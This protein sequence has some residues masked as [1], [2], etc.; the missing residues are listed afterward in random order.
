MYDSSCMCTASSSTVSPNA[1]HFTYR[2]F[3]SPNTVLTMPVNVCVYKR[4]AAID[5][6]GG[7]GSFFAR[8]KCSVIVRVLRAFPAASSN[9]FCCWMYCNVTEEHDWGVNPLSNISYDALISLHP[10]S[11]NLK[12]LSNKCCSKNVSLLTTRFV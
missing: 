4:T 8:L 10:K 11:I 3:F 6:G 5:F 1:F 2:S 12:V 7:R 9:S